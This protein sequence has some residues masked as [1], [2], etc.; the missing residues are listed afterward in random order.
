M[1]RLP[2][3]DPR[4]LARTLLR[5]FHRFDY[6]HLLPLMAGL[7]LTIGYALAAWRG[8][9]A[10]ACGSDWRSMAHGCRHVSR[11]TLAGYRLLAPG[12]DGAAYRGWHAQRFATESREEFEAQLVTAGRVEQLQCEVSPAIEQLCRNRRRGLVLLTPH[13]DSFFL[14]V[15]FLGRSGGTINLMTS[16]ITRDPRIPVEVQRHFAT[17]YR[18]LEHYLNGGRTLDMESGLR[19]FYR[20]LTANETLVVLADAPVLPG[21]ADSTADFLG[22]PRL[23]SGG[24]VR[25]AGRT[26]SELGCFVCRYLGGNRYRIELGPLGA[27]DDPTMVQQ[28]YRFFSTAI[29]QQPGHW[30]AA[31][32][33]PAMTIATAAAGETP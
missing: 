10:A 20:L 29:E 24:P 11:E 14:G 32:L 23:L 16:A 31:D 2:P 33:L 6:G 15:A 30:W 22:A 12:T 26:G 25:L 4:R 8:K 21:G 27:A 17:K 19:P 1:I 7:P 3:P 28:I 5:I 13:F 9:F 18:G